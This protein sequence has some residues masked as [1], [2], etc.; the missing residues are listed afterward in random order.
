MILTLEI[1]LAAGEEGQNDNEELW[2]WVIDI[3]RARSEGEIKR[4]MKM[5]SASFYL[6]SSSTA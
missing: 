4:G 6:N 5:S 3:Q 1:L 2:S